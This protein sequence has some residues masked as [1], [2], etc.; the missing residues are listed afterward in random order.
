M[1]RNGSDASN[2][3][4]SGC[5]R[6]ISTCSLTSYILRV[7]GNTMFS[8]RTS[9][10]LR[11]NHYS[12]QPSASVNNV[13][14]STRFARGVNR[15][16]THSLRFVTLYYYIFD[17][18]LFCDILSGFRFVAFCPGFSDTTRLW[19]HSRHLSSMVRCFL[20]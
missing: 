16:T 2:E 3:L 10:S 17:A 12:P 15:I 14:Y 4:I 8:T 13:I 19:L 7:H 6:T 20:G 1:P 18:S 11:T 9:P 5:A